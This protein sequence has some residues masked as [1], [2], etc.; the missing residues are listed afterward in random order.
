[1][2]EM[3]Y[4]SGHMAGVKRHEWNE[5]IDHVFKFQ[6]A[7]LDTQDEKKGYISFHVD[8]GWRGG[9]LSCEEIINEHF[10][11]F[12]EKHPHIDLRVTA[13]YVEHAPMEEFKFK[14]KKF[15]KGMIC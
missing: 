3:I 15:E 7:Q 1:M 4:Y 6:N 12:C 8:D 13:Q 9:G 11:E 2:S 5:V 14:G 10:K